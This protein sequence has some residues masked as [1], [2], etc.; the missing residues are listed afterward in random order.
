[1]MAS[2]TTRHPAVVFH[3][4]RHPL[5]GEGPLPEQVQPRSLPPLGPTS[6]T[7]N[8]G[9]QTGTGSESN[10]ATTPEPRDSECQPEEGKKGRDIKVNGTATDKKSSLG[11]FAK[12]IGVESKFA[13]SAL[14]FILVLL[15]ILVYGITK[16]VISSL[17][18]QEDPIIE[19]EYVRQPRGQPF[20]YITLCSLWF[21][22]PGLQES[23]FSNIEAK[24]YVDW[25]ELEPEQPTKVQTEFVPGKFF[26]RNGSCLSVDSGSYKAHSEY[27]WIEFAFEFTPSF[28]EFCNITNTTKSGHVSN[29]EKY[30]SWANHLP[31][32]FEVAFTSEQGALAASKHSGIQFY[33][34]PYDNRE[35]TTFLNTYKDISLDGMRDISWR[36]TSTNSLLHTMNARDISDG[37]SFLRFWLAFEST[38]IVILREVRP[39][40]FWQLFAVVVS[41]FGLV[42]GLWKWGCADQNKPPRKPLPVI[43][44]SRLMLQ[45]DGVGERD[46]EVG[47]CS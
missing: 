10:S 6:R 33:Y 8:D 16:A 9:S 5:D 2:G 29:C 23:W 45:M 28:E 24:Y 4:L 30:Y 42:A 44:Y 12:F 40:I 37:T 17:K 1:M 31:Q 15:G 43:L 32:E 41:F 18:E 21:V 34:I 13:C 35:V 47:T 27:E 3:A 14:L 25:E 11:D 7:N 19:T 26:G 20:P 46:R 39:S 38:D 36:A 22:D